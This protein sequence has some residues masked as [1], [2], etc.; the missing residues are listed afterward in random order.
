LASKLLDLVRLESNRVNQLVGG[1]LA[2]PDG[3]G[4]EPERCQRFDKSD[5]C[6]LDKVE[7]AHH[8]SHYRREP[9]QLALPCPVLVLE[10]VEVALSNAGGEALDDVL[11]PSLR[12]ADDL[13]ATHADLERPAQAAR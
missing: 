3:T 8:R 12:D 5:L 2:Q 1:A 10:V 7:G 4:V 13:V 9:V 11:E 6:T